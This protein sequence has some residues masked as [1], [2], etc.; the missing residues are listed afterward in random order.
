MRGVRA[1]DGV[2]QAFVPPRTR[3]NE[4]F[5]VSW[6]RNVSAHAQREPARPLARPLARPCACSYTRAQGG[7]LLRRLESGAL[8]MASRSPASVRCA[9]YERQWGATT[10]TAAGGGGAGGGAVADQV[11]SDPTVAALLQEAR[12]ARAC[13]G[14]SSSA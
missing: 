9:T 10:A 5:Q 13:L 4:V 11:V 6:E 3:H 8:F 14:P 7:V 12:S 2:L 1:G